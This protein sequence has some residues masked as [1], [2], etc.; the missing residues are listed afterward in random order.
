M[1]LQTVDHLLFFIYIY[2]CKLWQPI[3]LVSYCD[4]SGSAMP[5]QQ[6][7][8]QLQACLLRWFATG[9]VLSLLH[10]QD[11]PSKFKPVNSRAQRFKNGNSSFVEEP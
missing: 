1:A 7:K 10:L 4:V 11:S 5:N 9:C 3:H 6:H 8:V 2:I